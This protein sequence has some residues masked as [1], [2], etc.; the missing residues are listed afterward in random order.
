MDSQVCHHH[1]ASIFLRRLA[2]TIKNRAR[3]ESIATMMPNHYYDP[4]CLEVIWTFTS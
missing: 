2:I 3:G 4:D 1:L